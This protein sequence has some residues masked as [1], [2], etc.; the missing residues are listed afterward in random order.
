MTLHAGFRPFRRLCD[1]DWKTQSGRA[2]TRR[3]GPGQGMDSHHAV[4]AVTAPFRGSIRGLLRPLLACRAVSP[5]HQMD[6]NC[7]SSAVRKQRVR[8]FQRDSVLPSHC[9]TDT[10]KRHRQRIAESSENP[11]GSSIGHRFALR[12]QRFPQHRRQFFPSAFCAPDNL[13]TG[14]RAQIILLGRVRLQNL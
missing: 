8:I 1:R 4:Q 13:K 6:C 7:Q 9:S 11:T 12:R 3:S 5:R 10:E 14:L 2:E